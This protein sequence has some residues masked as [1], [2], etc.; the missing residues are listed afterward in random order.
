MKPSE[1]LVSIAITTYNRAHLVGRAI[2]SAINQ[3]YT[4]L[5]IVVVD[6]GSTDDTRAVLHRY[7]EKENRVRP[8]ILPVNVGVNGAKNKA[9]DSVSGEF[10]TLLDSDDEL[11]PNAIATFMAMFEDFGPGYG[12]MVCNAVDSDTGEWTGLGLFE[13]GDLSYRDA[14]CGRWRGDFSGLWRT[15]VMAGLR[16]AEDEAAREINVWNQIYRRTKVR[17]KHAAVLKYYRRTPNSVASIRFDRNYA[18][19]RLAATLSYLRTYGADIRLFCP[20]QFATLHRELALYATLAGKNTVA[21]GSS[22][23]AIRYD[24]VPSNWP[25]IAVALIPRFLFVWA[26][27]KYFRARGAKVA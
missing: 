11:L 4:N 22:L 21:L 25:L 17:Y 1:R 26:V 6:D 16:F 10:T 5:E 13:D 9:L 27:K 2:E 12:M 23:K 18:Q 3:S 7:A 15:S 19:R 24:S 20:K 14:L 8:V